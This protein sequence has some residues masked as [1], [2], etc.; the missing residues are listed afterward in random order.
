MQVAVAPVV[1]EKTFKI[2]G[3]NPVQINCF[4]CNQKIITAVRFENGSFTW[5]MCAILGF[6]YV[7]LSFPHFLITIILVHQFVVLRGIFNAP[8]TSFI[9]AQIVRQS[10]LLTN[11]FN[12]SRCQSIEMLKR[13]S[14]RSIDHLFHLIIDHLFYLIIDH[15][16]YLIIYQ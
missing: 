9:I 14:Q 6:W 7:D 3:K 5:L 8:R 16:L 15:L 13:K 12:Q 11:V 4:S 10:F 1:I 2:Y